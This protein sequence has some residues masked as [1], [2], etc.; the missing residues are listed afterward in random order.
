MNAPDAD[1]TPIAFAVNL[2]QNFP[3]QLFSLCC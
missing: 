3:A 1:A 2:R